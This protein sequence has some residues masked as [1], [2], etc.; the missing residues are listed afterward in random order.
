VI[1][2]T[3]R[4]AQRLNGGNEHL[5]KLLAIVEQGYSLGLLY[6]ISVP[7]Y[8]QQEIG[9]ESFFIGDGIFLPEFD[10]IIT[11][12]TL[13]DKQADIYPGIENLFRYNEFSLVVM[14][15]LAAPNNSQ[16]KLVGFF[17]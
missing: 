17:P 14:Q 2:L 6:M 9:F 1:S 15:V 10:P 7:Q 12:S 4:L 8:P 16:G 3:F 11:L 5:L 13:L